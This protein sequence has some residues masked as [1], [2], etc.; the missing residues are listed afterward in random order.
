E[1]AR[2]RSHSPT[3]RPQRDRRISTM[4]CGLSMGA[5]R[6][7][8]EFSLIVAVR[9]HAPTGHFHQYNAIAR[10]KKLNRSN[11]SFRETATC[12][13]RS[14]FG[15]VKSQT[16]RQSQT[17]ILTLAAAWKIDEESLTTK[18]AAFAYNGCFPQFA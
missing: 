16:T 14:F 12:S 15:P 11:V 1:R 2:P 7:Q 13:N 17:P 10:P 5:K 9:Q 3:L 6:C 4:N 8:Y 18:P